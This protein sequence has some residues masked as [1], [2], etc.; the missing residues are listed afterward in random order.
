MRIRRRSSSITFILDIFSFDQKF[1][2]VIVKNEFQKQINLKFSLHLKLGKGLLAIMMS[3]IWQIL[4]SKLLMTV[5]LTGQNEEDPI[6]M[7]VLES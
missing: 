3:L 2:R 6:K 5:L 7:F 4:S 1:K